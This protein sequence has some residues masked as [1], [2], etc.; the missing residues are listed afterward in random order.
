MDRVAKTYISSVHLL[1]RLVALYIVAVLAAVSSAHAA[2]SGRA[3]R[4][5]ML[6]SGSKFAP[7]SALVEQSAQDNC[8]GVYYRA[9]FQ[10]NSIVY[11]VLSALRALKKS[12][13]W[14]FIELTSLA[15]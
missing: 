1:G 8:A 3:K 6:V 9:G 4:V 10:G 13:P 11:I 2:E 14:R 7:G 12:M 15:G 5:L